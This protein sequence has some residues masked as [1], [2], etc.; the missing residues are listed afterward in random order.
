MKAVLPL[1]LLAIVGLWP[2][3]DER[4]VLRLKVALSRRSFARWRTRWGL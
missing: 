3:S 1:L 4:R 2:D